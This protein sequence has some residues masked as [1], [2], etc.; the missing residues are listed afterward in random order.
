MTKT[1]RGR[2]NKEKKKSDDEVSSE[3]GAESDI[4]SLVN[5]ANATDNENEMNVDAQPEQQ[6][7]KFTDFIKKRPVQVSVVSAEESSVSGKS[8]D[9]AGTKR[10]A[11][12][13]PEKI[14]TVKKSTLS[15]DIL[16]RD[17][18][19]PSGSTNMSE[20]ER[21]LEQLESLDQPPVRR[22][23]AN[24]RSNTTA[25]TNK[26]GLQTSSG[27]TRNTKQRPLLP[28]P[29]PLTTR[30]YF[31]PLELEDDNDNNENN[32]NGI[33]NDVEQQTA[34]K[35]HRK[36]APAPIIMQGRTSDHKGL[37]NLNT[38]S[39]SWRILHHLHDEI[40]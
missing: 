31:S 18:C 27:R 17:I 36:T 14:E 33:N 1:R 39:G 7:A 9:N 2:K 19:R 38:G 12:E 37:N 40:T 24:S 3:S 10:K 5:S 28:T 26:S 4:I 16:L 32:T 15:K 22:S 25:Q 30:N 23:A 35:P 21:A 34:T 20:F 29:P 11:A 13:S 8:V 6:R